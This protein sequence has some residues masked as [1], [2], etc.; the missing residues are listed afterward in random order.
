MTSDDVDDS[1]DDH[2]H[3]SDSDG[4]QLLLWERVTSG[5]LGVIL[6]GVGAWA[7]FKSANQAG[8][9]FLLL[10][11]AVML[12]ICIQGTPLVKLGGAGNSVE[13]DRRRQAKD[14][15][16]ALIAK[17][18]KP[19]IRAAI[20]KGA[21]A[22]EPSLRP[23]AKWAEY[24]A[25]VKEA[26]QRVLDDKATVR[27][28]VRT[29]HTALDLVVTRGANTSIAIEV[30][31]N[32]IP[33]GTDQVAQAAGYAL[34]STAMIIAANGFTAAASSLAEQRGVV[35]VP[36][37]APDDDQALRAAFDSIFKRSN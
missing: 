3:D 7:V 17:E 29:G 9:A 6:T 12:L 4:V 8:T 30:K 25:K 27:A 36:W 21:A 31:Y 33:L 5:L 35:L 11:G 13:L 37:R 34:G 24:E 19:E 23:A 1:T 2:V 26:V 28:E 20:L 22:A 32:S 15:T 18:P 10:A 14:R 16:K